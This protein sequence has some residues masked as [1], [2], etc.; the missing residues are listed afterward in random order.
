MA[1]VTNMKARATDIP[2]DAQY[3]AVC[4]R[5][6]PKFVSDF[7]R[8]MAEP[9]PIGAP[10]RYDIE[11]RFWRDEEEDESRRRAL[12]ATGGAKNNATHAP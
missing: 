4:A 3:C 11:R 9:P 7:E 1:R 5:M 10:A 6:R 12:R 2:T 8:D